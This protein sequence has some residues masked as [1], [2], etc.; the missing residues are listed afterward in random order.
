MAEKTLQQLVEEEQAK[1]TAGRTNPN[2]LGDM[3]Q[4]LEAPAAAATVAYLTGGAGNA[5]LGA[6][7]A[8]APTAANLIPAAVAGAKTAMTPDATLPQAAGQGIATGLEAPMRTMA[9]NRASSMV[10]TANKGKELT[11]PTRLSL[12]EVDKDG[13]PIYKI[14]PAAT[15]LVPFTSLKIKGATIDPGVKTKKI[16]GDTVA[17]GEKT[18]NVEAD[19]KKKIAEAG[20]ADRSPGVG[21]TGP[22]LTEAAAKAR[23]AMALTQNP[24]ITKAVMDDAAKNGWVSAFKK[25]KAKGYLQ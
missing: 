21:G 3:L 4:N 18:S 19:T 20:R 2:N 16:Q 11:D 25:L 17:P 23:V 24:D 6:S 7:D 15:Q 9:Q 8:F 22:K 14:P 1:I 5:A 13:N 10:A 12:A